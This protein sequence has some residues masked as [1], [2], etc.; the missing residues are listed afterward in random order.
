MRL[1]DAAKFQDFSAKDLT[2]PDPSRTRNILSAFINFIKFTEQRQ[3]FINSLRN[4]SA[5]L[6]EERATVLR[7]LD[8]TRRELAATR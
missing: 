8:I 7:Q 2:A 4:E 6:A 1:A 3:P 5:R